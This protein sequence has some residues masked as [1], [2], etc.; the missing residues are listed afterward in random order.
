M[1]SQPLLRWLSEWNKQTYNIHCTSPKV[2]KNIQNNFYYNIQI[3][4]MANLLQILYHIWG[5]TVYWIAHFLFIKGRPLK[6]HE[7]WK[8]I[9]MTKKQKASVIQTSKSS[10]EGMWDL[11][12]KKCT[13]VILQCSSYQRPWQHISYRTI[14]HLTCLMLLNIKTKQL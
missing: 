10:K 9:T 2:W 14:A 5:R 11:R 13:G 4:I 8:I 12:V 7:T 6:M 3:H 1:N